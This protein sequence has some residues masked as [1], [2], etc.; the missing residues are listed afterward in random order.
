MITTARRVAKPV[1]LF[2]LMLFAVGPGFA[3]AG[4]QPAA[5]GADAAV[6]ADAAAVS[7][8][9]HAPLPIAPSRP[10]A[11]HSWTFPADLTPGQGSRSLGDPPLWMDTS[12]PDSTSDKTGSWWSRRTTAQKT[13][14]IVGMVV[15]AAGIYAIASNHSGGG[16]GGG[17]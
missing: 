5:T 12:A 11:A 4:P 8:A 1:S 17:Y 13:W 16:G 10:R 9:D 2:I 14:F 6:A 7:T 15:G 3:S